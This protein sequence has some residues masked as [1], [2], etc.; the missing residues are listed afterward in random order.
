MSRATG[1]TWLLHLTGGEPTA[2]PGF[3]DLAAALSARHYLSMNSNLSLASVAAFAEAVD[4]A[5]VS[6]INGGLH[7]AERAR[8]SGLE[9]FNANIVLL[10]ERGFPVFVSVVATPEVL[11][12]VEAVT[13]SVAA[14]G[15]VP[16]PKIL[17]GAHHGKAYPRAY[18]G[19]ERRSF[20]MMSRHARDVYAD[21]RIARP[22]CPTID[23]FE[24]DRF[25][26]GTPGYTGKSCEA[27]RRFA[28]LE[29]D[30]EAYR[31][32]SR[33]PLGNVLTGSFA[34]WSEARRCD[35]HYCFYFCRKYTDRTAA[36]LAQLSAP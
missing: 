16:V 9:I 6:F 34:P 25:L 1:L 19:A 12:D 18:S 32:G 13:R 3:A 26:G 15:L 30:G 22:E 36:R 31:C 20:E 7:P 27:G 11:A 24:D 10:R 33:E 14:T 4:P 23:P 17:R 21:W 29:P 8:K 2:Y 28:R 35:T 5:R